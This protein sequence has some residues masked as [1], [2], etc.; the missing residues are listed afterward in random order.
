MITE[1]KNKDA[2]IEKIAIKAIKDPKFIKELVE[3]LQSKEENVRYNCHK[4]LVEITKEKPELIYPYWYIFQNML[5]A[6]NTYWRSSATHLIANLTTV[7]IEN[8]FERIFES[9]YEKLNDS[10]IIAA[11]LTGYS[12]KIAKAKSGLRDKITDKL[13]NIDKTNQKHK[14]LMKAGAIQAFDEYFEEI[15]GKDKKR[16]LEFVKKA[17]TGDSPK[18]KKVATEFL[19][20]WRQE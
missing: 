3:N 2:N 18:T 17:S 8:K 1:L 11:N 12:G 7:D 4:I 13:L 5:D 6:K 10:I 16:I 9:Y 14:D 20:K 15:G 19:K